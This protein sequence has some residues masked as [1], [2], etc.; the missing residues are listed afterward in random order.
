MTA[1]QL[2]LPTAFIDEI[3]SF[4]YDNI[5]KKL[6][7]ADFPAVFVPRLGTFVVKKKALADQIIR[8]QYFV[9]KMERAEHLSVRMYEAMLARRTD[10][11][12]LEELERM[13][14]EEYLRKVEVKQKRKDYTNDKSDQTMEGAQ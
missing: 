4:Y 8:H 12:Q 14:Q 11:A 5:Q 10:I 7:A 9:D 2:G 13:M 6:S 3:M 1:K